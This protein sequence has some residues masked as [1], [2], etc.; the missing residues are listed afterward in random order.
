MPGCGLQ[1]GNLSFEANG[2]GIVDFRD[3]TPLIPCYFQ[4]CWIDS[5]TVAIF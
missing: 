2:N 3:Q 1:K 5:P 4:I